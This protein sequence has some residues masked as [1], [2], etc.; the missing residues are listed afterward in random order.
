M[1]VAAPKQT[2]LAPKLLSLPKALAILA[3]D[4]KT[5]AIPIP[6]AIFP[7]TINT[8]I[9]GIQKKILRGINFVKITKKYF[10][11]HATPRRAHGSYRK[12][13]WPQRIPV[14][15]TKK[16]YKKKKREGINL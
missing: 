15:I 1:G 16:N 13:R 9:F 5:Q 11:G 4:G 7:S 14:K 12:N 10:P 2:G 8:K 6:F 3:C